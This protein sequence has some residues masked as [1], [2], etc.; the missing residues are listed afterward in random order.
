MQDRLWALRVTVTN[1][2]APLQTFHDA[3]T[4]DQKAKLDAQQPTERE[5]KKRAPA[6]AAARLCYAQAQRA[7]QWPADQ[8]ARAVRP[9]KDQQESLGALSETS[10]KMSLM[11]MGSCPQKGPATPLER[12]DVTLDWLDTML[13]AT[14]TVMI[15][16]DDFYR[17]LSDEQKSKL[18]TLSL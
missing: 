4:S 11:A 16:V 6:G 2:R 18:D 15:A 17:S 12:L 13:F 7:P 14:A 9:N 1:L 5:S 8:I 3:L 10:S